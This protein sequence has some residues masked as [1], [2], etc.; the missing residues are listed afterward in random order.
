MLF[1]N[2]LVSIL[3]LTVSVFASNKMTFY[4]CPDECET[5]EN[6]SCGKE[7][8]TE[9]FA[10]LVNILNYNVNIYYKLDDI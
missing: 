4:G 10:A 5:Q 1:N 9:Y 8:D 6:P 3:L 7:I 2:I